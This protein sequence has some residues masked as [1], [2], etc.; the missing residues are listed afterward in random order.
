[1]FLIAKSLNS[2]DLL[3]EWNNLWFWTIFPGHCDFSAGSS[4]EFSIENRKKVNWLAKNAGDCLG[5]F[6]QLKPEKNNSGN[7]FH[8]SFSLL[9][10]VKL[11]KQCCWTLAV[12][13]AQNSQLEPMGLTATAPAPTCRSN[14]TIKNPGPHLSGILCSTE[15]SNSLKFRDFKKLV[16][17]C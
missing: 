6:L 14:L 2:K 8:F 13:T 15:S 11:F 4:Q 5:A 17:G 1:M 7:Y 12:D 9:S 10:F 3:G 16:S